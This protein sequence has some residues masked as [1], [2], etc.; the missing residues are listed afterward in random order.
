M[1]AKLLCLQGSEFGEMDNILGY[2]PRLNLA[3]ALLLPAGRGRMRR[4]G[5]LD[6]GLNN[7]LEPRLSLAVHGQD[8]GPLIIML[9]LGLGLKAGVE[10]PAIS[11]AGYPEIKEVVLAA[12]AERH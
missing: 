12:S 2:K 5:P 9:F 7:V 4:L 6:I 8:L 1:A 10:R 11:L 3:Q